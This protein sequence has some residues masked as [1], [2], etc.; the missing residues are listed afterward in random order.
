MRSSVAVIIGLAVCAAVAASEPESRALQAGSAPGPLR[1][2]RTVHAVPASFSFDDLSPTEEGALDVER[3]VAATVATR[4][5]P[6]ARPPARRPR[7]SATTGTPGGTPQAVLAAAY[8]QAVAGAPDGCNLRL[9]HLAAIG[10]IESGSIGGR[11]VTTEHR[12]TPPIYGPLLDGGPFATIPDTDGGR[13]DGD[14]EWDRA[15]GPMQFIPGTWSWAGADG[16][17]DGRADPQNVYDAATAAAGYLCRGGRDLSRPADLR[18]AIWSYNQSADYVAAALDWVDY[19]E[20]E[21]VGALA[22]VAFRVGSGGRASD[23]AQPEPGPTPATAAPTASPTT[24][25]RPTQPPVTTGHTTT[26]APTPTTSTTTTSTPQPTTTTQPTMPTTTTATTTSTAS[27]TGTG[28]ATASPTATTSTTTEPD[29][30]RSTD[31]P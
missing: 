26:P 28:T 30:D 16:D 23:L 3:P 22:G 17:G 9:S 25:S 29:D 2:A 6:V 4:Q 13:H 20:A 7:P 11:E 21:G 19:F 1:E 31:A 24:S 5:K 14:G 27:P 18:A 10:Q 15:V 8:R 12:V